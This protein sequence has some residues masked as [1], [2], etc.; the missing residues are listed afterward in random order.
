MFKDHDLGGFKR[1]VDFIK[2]KNSITPLIIKLEGLTVTQNCMNT[3]C[4]HA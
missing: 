2:H 4:N 3:I 1:I